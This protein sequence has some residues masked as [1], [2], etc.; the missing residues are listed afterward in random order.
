MGVNFTGTYKIKIKGE[1]GDTVVFRFGER[2]Y[3]DGTLNPMTTVCGQIKRPGVG[4]PGAPDIAWQT[5]TYVIG[6]NTEAW[7]QPEFTFHTYRYMEIAGLNK[8]PEMADIEGLTLNTTVANE[9]SFSCS[10]NLIHSIQ[11]ATERTFLANLQSV[12]SDCPAREKFGYGG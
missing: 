7:F 6:S 8:A 5:D 9:N 10:S 2:V 3:S 12:Q 4:G 11:E 1:T